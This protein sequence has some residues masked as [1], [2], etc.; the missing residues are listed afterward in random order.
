MDELIGQAAA[1]LDRGGLVVVPSDTVYGL[2]VD[3]LNPAAVKRL[4]EFKQRPPGK[5]ISVFVTNLEQAKAIVSFNKKQVNI[6]RQL[7]PGPFTI[8]LKSK[9][10]VVKDLESEKGTLGVR[11]PQFAFI[12]Q[13]TQRFGRPITATSA[14]LSGRSPHYSV[15]SFLKATP[16]GK[17]GLIDFMIDFGQLPRNK[18]STVIDLTNNNLTLIRKGD[19]IPPTVR[20]SSLRFVSKTPSDTEKIARFLFNK[21]GTGLLQ[22]PLIFLLEG[23][24]GAGKTVF[25]KGIAGALGI[26]NIISPTFVI[27]YEYEVKLSPVNKLYHFDFYKIESAEELAHLG[28][29]DILKP[30]NLICIEWGQKTASIFESLK[31]QGKL[32]YVK[33]AY[34]GKNKREIEVYEN[35][36]H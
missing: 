20:R 16:Q 8:V 5:A 19:L 27:Y 11:I 21:Y 2:A 22:K 4:I 34:I 36:S 7:L 6:L 29:T 15:D 14:N 26:T 32:I 17:K 24:L 28:M 35:F 12:N 30:K 31:K 13:L 3:A 23:E 9:H 10:L 25:V 33:I 18:P 1:V